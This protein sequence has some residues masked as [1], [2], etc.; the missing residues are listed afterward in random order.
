M[1]RWKKLADRLLFVLFISTVS[2]ISYSV[3]DGKEVSSYKAIDEVLLTATHAPSGWMLE[4]EVRTDEAT[5]NTFEQIYGVRAQAIINQVFVAN[6]KRLQI[7]YCLF[8]HESAAGMAVLKM[9][10]LVGNASLIF[11]K[12]NV[13]ME[14]ISEDPW[15]KQEALKRLRPDPINEL[16]VTHKKLPQGW[17][18]WDIVLVDQSKMPFFENRMGARI[19]TI[20][21][22]IFNVGKEVVKVNFVFCSDKSERE[23]AYTHMKQLVSEGNMVIKKNRAVIEIVASKENLRQVA[24]DIL[25]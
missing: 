6:G 19:D 17:T 23:K 15:L 9:K 25:D 12:K 22:Q 21:N 2:L 13:V 20:I 14:L 4:K 7:N 3:S 8:H 24:K 18:L 10:S 11:E 5:L 16:L 1:K